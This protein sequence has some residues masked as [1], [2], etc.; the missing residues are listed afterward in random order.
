MSDNEEEQYRIYRDDTRIP[1]RYGVK[2]YQKNAVHHKKY[3]HPPIKHMQKG[4]GVKDSVKNKKRKI[5]NKNETSKDSP[6]KKMQKE[7]DDTT[8]EN[9]YCTVSAAGSIVKR[10]DEYNKNIT[11]LSSGSTNNVKDVINQCTIAS[12]LKDCNI[13]IEND[14]VSQNDIKIII[15]HLFL[16]E[17][18]DDFFHFFKLCK[19]INKKD[20]FN[21]LKDLH[22][23]LVGPYDVLRDEFLNFKVDN[24]EALLRHWRY[25]YDPPEF[26]TIVKVDDKDGLHFGY[27]RD[28]IA[29]KP[30]FVAKNK[31][32][33][34][35]LIKPVA[36][37]IFGA[38]D[39]YIEEKLKSANPFEKTSITL[40]H[41]KLKDFAKDNKI[42]LDKQTTNMQARERQVVART[43]HKAGIVVPYN[44]KTELGYRSL[45][46]TD[47]E[48]RQILEQIRQAST[49]EARKASMS[50]LEEVIRLATIAADECDFGTC[51]ELGHDLFSS[52]VSTIQNKTLNMLSLA[53]NLLQ[54]PQFLKILQAHLKDRTRSLNPSV[55]ST[56]LMINE[57]I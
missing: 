44:K 18:P 22:L 56:T 32:A 3:K 7:N 49:A 4:K 38:I 11:E 26:Q 28:D 10:N 23:Q 19:D 37:N 17:M 34:N 36:E 29:E 1:C 42:K 16:T 33:V 27:W 6:K 24:K 5:E 2:C 31:A 30:V 52:G 45:A 14:T 43:F 15:L 20:C 40:L 13:N 8:N 46:I 9:S 35:C 51:L 54:R 25:Y 57:K 48:L 39:A 55:L 50:K 41:K 21:A 53:Y 47:S 12:L